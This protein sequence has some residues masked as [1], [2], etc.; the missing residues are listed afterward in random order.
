MGEKSN[1]G[2]FIGEA[3]NAACNDTSHTRLCD[4]GYSPGQAA[5]S[6]GAEQ[7]AAAA[8]IAAAATAAATALDQYAVCWQQF[9][10]NDRDIRADTH[11]KPI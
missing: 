8:A 6:P 1:V 9:D 2:I 11:A 7:T 5:T 10:N 3:A 4:I